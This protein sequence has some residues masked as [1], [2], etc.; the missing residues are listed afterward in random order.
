MSVV[1][2]SSGVLGGGSQRLAWLVLSTLAASVAWLLG[3]SP[4]FVGGALICSVFPPFV[5][6]FLHGSANETDIADVERMLWI[7]L[8]TAAVA[9]SGGLLSPLSILFAIPLLMLRL[10]GS[11]R[12]L[13]EVAV[14]TFSGYVLSGLAAY[15][16]GPLLTDVNA[17]LVSCFAV[18]GLLQ[19]AWI[20][21]CG[22]PDATPFSAPLKPV[23]APTRDA[24]E[25]ALKLRQAEARSAHLES[26]LERAQESQSARMR[27]FAQTSHEIGNPLNVILGFAEMMKNE[28]FGPMPERY[29][30]Y[31]QLIFEGGQSLRLLIDDVLDLSRVEAGRYEIHPELE[32][33]AEI[34]EEAVRFMHHAAERQ[35][36]T[37]AYDGASSVEIFADR[38]ALNQIALNLIS[39]AL[40]FTPEGGQVIVSAVR[41]RNGALLAVTD[42]GAGISAEELKKLSNAFTQGEAGK[43]EKGSGLGLS[44][45]RAL[46]ELHGG[47][48]DI[49][50][51]EGGGSTVAVFF[52]DEPAD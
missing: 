11:P 37:L 1:Q 49:E 7:A 38:K 14:L 36:V 45:V 15:A 29:K 44:V 52:P 5:A 31:T 27:F 46:A 13:L 10:N 19:A 23:R 6:M 18:A 30:E 4:S 25:L 24:R 51:R 35:K 21:V 40:K 33:L 17:V 26:E 9:A 39:N 42:T 34:G 50:S 8:A 48:L 2:N 12:R 32:D 3:A 20:A 47:R 41:A 16:S 22:Q 43:R 28:T